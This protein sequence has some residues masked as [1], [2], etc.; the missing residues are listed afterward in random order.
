MKKTIQGVAAGLI[1]GA[2]SWVICPVLFGTP[3][4]FDT[5]A[6]LIAGQGLLTLVAVVIV[7]KGTLRALPGLIIGMYA[8]IN[9]AIFVVGNSEQKAWFLLGLMTT[10][11]LVVA[12]LV[13]GLVSGAVRAYRERRTKID[14]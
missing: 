7:F 2:I 9:L 4:P 1:A 11:V 14:I 6:G 12:P 8:G 13:G 3:E 5:T 10:L